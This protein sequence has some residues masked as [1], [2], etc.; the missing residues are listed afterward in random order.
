VND[1]AF[2]KLSRKVGYPSPTNVSRLRK[3]QVELATKGEEKSLL[4]LARAEDVFSSKERRNYD[5]WAEQIAAKAKSALVEEDEAL[6]AT[7]GTPSGRVVAPSG[8][9]PIEPDDE[10]AKGDLDEIITKREKDA[11]DIA[12]RVFLK[13][14]KKVGYPSADEVAR[15][16]KLQKAR[17]GDPSL[18]Q[19]AKE[20]KLLSAKR[21][22]NYDRWAGQIA[23]R[24][25]AAIVEDED[26]SAPAG[27]SG[28]VVARSTE[29]LAVAEDEAREDLDALIARLG[30]IKDRTF[31]KLAKRVGYPTSKEI[32][33]LRK[34][35]IGRT[36]EIS[37][38][39]LAREE[40]IL[41]A[42]QQKN[43]DRWA[44]QIAAKAK[45]ALVEDEE[46]L[47]PLAQPSGRIVVPDAEEVEPSGEEQA[48]DLDELIARFSKDE[49]QAEA[50]P[51]LKT[52]SAGRLH[53]PSAGKLRTASAGR[54]P[55]SKGP[56]PASTPTTTIALAAVAAIV[57][58]FLILAGNSG[59]P[60]PAAPESEQPVAVVTKQPVKT[61]KPEADAPE[62]PARQGGLFGGSEEG[63]QASLDAREQAKALLEQARALI[64]QGDAD[65]ARACVEEARGLD[66]TCPGLDEVAKKIA[67]AKPS[68]ETLPTDPKDGTGVG[69]KPSPDDP[70]PETPT[71]PPPGKDPKVKGPAPGAP[72][73]GEPVVEKTPDGRIKAKYGTDT[74]GRKHGDYVEYHDN[75]KPSVRAK[76][77]AG[78]RQGV[79]NEFYPDGKPK[80]KADYRK[81]K[82]HGR[83]IEWDAK[84]RV[85]VDAL[86]NE[87][88][89]IYPRSAALI[90]AM[91][92]EIEHSPVDAPEGPKNRKVEFPPMDPGAQARPLR[93]LRAYRYLAGVPWDVDL[94][95]EYGEWA[96][97]GA[98]LLD[99]I[100]RLDH[101]PVKPD[102]CADSLYETG[103]KGTSQG[104]L[105]EG[106]ADLNQCIDGWIDDSDPKNI[107]RV[108]HRR[109]CLNPSMKKTA[110]GQQSAK[111]TV[112][113]AHDRSRTDFQ[114][115]SIVRY[116]AQGLFPTTHI[117]ADAA[118]SISL[119]E[120]FE[121][122]VKEQIQ[123][124]VR[125]CDENM[126]KGQP[127]EQEYFNVNNE[128]YGQPYCIIFR[129]KPI[130]YMA[131]SGYWVDVKG[132][133][134]AE[135][136]PYPIGY[137]VEFFEPSR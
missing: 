12:D 21:Q 19:L 29:E 129:M 14:S 32:S 101:T 114:E 134:T 92:S 79:W 4:E 43:Y 112:L 64:D 84:G 93:R 96:T 57:A 37:L 123:V 2:L 30:D 53:T 33:R 85:T 66:A 77:N 82:L 97:A 94:S 36:G 55:T 120:E 126:R 69:P 42:K 90:N 11:P 106:V 3:L 83:V 23:A 7:P 18:F 40:K 131:G 99:L 24:A 46:S 104:N 110:I 58:V 48:A 122:P 89:V 74:K 137:Y 113:L 86:W 60:P 9:E 108:G 132:V 61:N 88:E 127:L 67:A 103:Y 116:P 98:K 133:K 31:L 105:Y 71:P 81:D 80:K 38:F 107:D 130:S 117:H 65:G 63:P 45:A 15:L 26:A 17:K 100:Q 6:P 22:K 102:G 59:S 16:R 20:E 35:Q 87:G 118:W 78:E 70:K 27:L 5:R 119:N 1:R 13:L 91:L 10:E 34:L 8:V 39:H 56:R 111:W 49:T 51:D 109:W 25:R 73:P 75:G 135:G 52:P 72:K 76:Y 47:A 121:A 41:S 125:P 95:F 68:A 115:P 62:P 28:R 44:G 136:K 124:T 54:A 128:G 50:K